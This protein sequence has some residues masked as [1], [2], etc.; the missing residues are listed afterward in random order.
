MKHI[1]R[2]FELY[3]KSNYF[4]TTRTIGAFLDF[5]CTDQLVRIPYFLHGDFFGRA[6][7]FLL[8]VLA[9]VLNT[10]FL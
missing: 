3:L 6:I 2:E 10:P 1:L 4:T 8:M 7:K 9:P 5:Y